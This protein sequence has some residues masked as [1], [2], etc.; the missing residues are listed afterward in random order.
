MYRHTLAVFMVAVATSR[1]DASPIFYEGFDGAFSQPWI[2]SPGALPPVPLDP[3]RPQTVQYAGAP[4]FS[5]CTVDGSDVLR[6]NTMHG[7]SWTRFGFRSDITVA[8]PSIEVEA[9]I[10]TLDQGGPN[11]DGL[12]DLWL[13]DSHDPSKYVQVGLFADWFDTR[14]AWY[15]G[16][17]DGPFLMPDFAFTSSTWYRLRI[18]RSPESL[19]V[20]VWSDAGDAKLVWHSFDC[21]VGLPGSDFHI[22][23][24][25]WQGGVDGTH[26]LLSGVDYI[27]VVPETS[28]LV[29]FGMAATLVPINFWR[30]SAA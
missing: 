13:I 27:Q 5:F 28:T 25:Q 3:F 1:S 21:A 24:S 17:S 7:P 16:S 14:R 10:N 12:F 9:R 22:G 11:I 2:S 29:V 19:E 6:M 18:S 15:F 20:S 4:T 23:F 26:S 8:G 30:R